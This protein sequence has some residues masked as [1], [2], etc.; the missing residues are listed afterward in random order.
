M[1]V[2]RPVCT[3]ITREKRDMTI[4]AYIMYNMA[5]DVALLRHPKILLFSRAWFGF[6]ECGEKERKES[7]KKRAIRTRHPSL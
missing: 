4:S 2:V 3:T 6:A 7:E 1:W 5:R